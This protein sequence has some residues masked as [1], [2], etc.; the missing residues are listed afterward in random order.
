MGN[1]INMNILQRI[2][3]LPQVLQDLIWEYNVEKHRDQM[4]DLCCEYFTAAYLKCA[5]CNMRITDDIFYSVDYFIF[6]KYKMKQNWCSNLCWDIETDSHKKEVYENCIEE[7][8][9]KH[10]IQYK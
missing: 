5:V 1:T 6:R 10:S 9:Q 7:Y 4:K 2:K 3:S 8:I